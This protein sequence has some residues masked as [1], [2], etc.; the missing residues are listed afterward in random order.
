M[1]YRFF[2][3]KWAFSGCREIKF[4]SEHILLAKP[5]Q[6]WRHSCPF[7]KSSRGLSGWTIWSKLSLSVLSLSI[8]ISP[9]VFDPTI[10]APLLLAGCLSWSPEK[11]LLPKS[12]SASWHGTPPE[13]SSKDKTVTH[14]SL[15][16]IASRKLNRGSQNEHKDYKKCSHSPRVNFRVKSTFVHGLERSPSSLLALLL[17]LCLFLHGVFDLQ[18][19]ECDQIGNWVL[20]V[21]RGL[22]QNPYTGRV[23]F[24]ANTK[25]FWQVWFLCFSFGADGG[26]SDF[27]IQFLLPVRT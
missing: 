26:E 25:D 8:F 10:E 16:E 3:K 12:F 11:H 20:M 18:G 17:S 15:S 21:I 1:P 23:N 22:G 27:I 2:S 19:G 4:Q 24:S 6:P 14:S 5:Q 9:V 7:L 13:G